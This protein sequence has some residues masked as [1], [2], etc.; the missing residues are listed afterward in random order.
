[1]RLGRAKAREFIPQRI[2]SLETVAGVKR[3]LSVLYRAAKKGKIPTED[4]FRL[5]RILMCI[6]SCI[7]GVEI[8]Q[9]IER[10]EH[11]DDEKP[12]GPRLV[13]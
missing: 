8:E 5:A 11:G 12:P 10:L 1:M 6:V 3:E 7:Q 9:R 2:G 4:A 13:A